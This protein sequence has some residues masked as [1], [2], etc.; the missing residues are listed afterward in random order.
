MYSGS[1]VLQ[2]PTLY[3]L[4]LCA[5][6]GILRVRFERRASENNLQHDYDTMG[7]FIL[8]DKQ[9]S[10]G[11][12]TGRFTKSVWLTT[13]KIVIWINKRVRTSYDTYFISNQVLKYIP[14]RTFWK[15]KF[16]FFRCKINRKF[17]CRHLAISH[18]CY[19]TEVTKNR[20]FISFYK[21][22]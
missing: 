6:D 7:R 1:I 12:G 17:Y 9:P 5:W 22:L 10:V 20:E 19:F 2:N 4:H 8:R 3:S 16:Y 11:R 13:Y 15:F 14:P 18:V 21:S